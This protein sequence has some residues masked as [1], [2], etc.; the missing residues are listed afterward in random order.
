MSR[1]GGLDLVVVDHGGQV[2]QAVLARAHRGL[3]YR[4]FIDLAVSHHHDH[5]AVALLHANGERHANTDRKTVAESAG[6]SLNAGHLASFR[7]AAKD[8]VAAAERVECVEREETL[9]SQHD[10]ER[11]AAM[12]L[13]QDHAV[14]VTPLRLRWPIAQDVIVK[15]AHNLD[16]RHRRADVAALATFKRAHHQLAQIFRPLIERRRGAA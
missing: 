4:A 6:R 13:A 10:I 14:T 1:P 16:K 15:H 9:V 8:R 3:P 2:G 5:A 12:T 7:M 11:D